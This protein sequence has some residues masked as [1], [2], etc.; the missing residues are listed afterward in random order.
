MGSLSLT[1][2]NASSESRAATAGGVT[3]HAT[4]PAHRRVARCRSGRWR[5]SRPA[6]TGVRVR[7]THRLVTPTVHLP[8]RA[9]PGRWLPAAAGA[10][11]KLPE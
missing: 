8:P 2:L 6:G 3:F 5:P 7:S 1:Y 10:P 11:C 9:T 4:E